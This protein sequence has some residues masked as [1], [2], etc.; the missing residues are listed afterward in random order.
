MPYIHF[1]VALIIM[2]KWKMFKNYMHNE[3]GIT[4]EDIREWVHE[5]VKEE[6]ERLVA[7]EWGR[8]DVKKVVQDMIGD[9]RYF[10]KDHLNQDIKE[11]VAN[12]IMKHI[13]L[14]P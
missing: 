6:A 13:K 1:Y 2:D 11:A 4:K 12:E 7:N 8:F 5:A 10:S 9:K 3:L 14:F